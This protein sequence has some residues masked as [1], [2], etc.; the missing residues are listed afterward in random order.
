MRL[1]FDDMAPILKRLTESDD[2]SD[3]ATQAVGRVKAIEQ[4]VATATKV[5]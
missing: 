3:A 1:D 4:T 5:R 2:L